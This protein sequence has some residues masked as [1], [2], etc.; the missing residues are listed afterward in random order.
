MKILSMM[1][2]TQ[3]VM[4]LVMLTAVIVFIITRKSG[5]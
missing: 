1:L 2:G 5:K 4:L 3:E